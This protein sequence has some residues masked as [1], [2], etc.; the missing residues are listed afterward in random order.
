M[1][2]LI[3]I[4]ASILSAPGVAVSIFGQKAK[5]VKQPIKK[6]PTIPE[7]LIGYGTA[8]AIAIAA[9]YVGLSSEELKTAICD[10]PTIPSVTPTPDPAAELELE[11]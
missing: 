9:P 7:L 6:P 5:G 8:V 2:A 11:L 1:G 3:P 4:I 10:A